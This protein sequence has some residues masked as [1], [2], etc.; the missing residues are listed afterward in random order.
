MLFVAVIILDL[1]LIYFNLLA[2][3]KRGDI[4]IS[5]Q[6]I[7]ALAL[8]FKCFIAWAKIFLS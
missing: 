6:S 5:S 3:L 1:T 7:E 8:A 4:N 2:F